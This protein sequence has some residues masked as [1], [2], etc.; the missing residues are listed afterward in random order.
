MFP[1][2]YAMLHIGETC[3]AYKQFH[4][5]IPINDINRVN[6]KWKIQQF[7]NYTAQGMHKKVSLSVPRI[8]LKQQIDF[9]NPSWLTLVMYM[10][11]L[12]FGAL[13]LKGAVLPVN[14]IIT[15][16]Y[17]PLSDHLPTPW[18][19]SFLNSLNAPSFGLVS[20][21]WL[22]SSLVNCI[23]WFS[24]IDLIPPPPTRPCKLQL[25]HHPTQD[26]WDISV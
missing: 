8:T 2:L 13:A 5:V 15:L 19:S 16:L 25:Q 20:G 7:E 23:A 9:F 11:Y 26:A 1:C 10:S 14:N 18:L 12:L 6:L 22:Q 24:N 3:T 21:S 4:N 17:I